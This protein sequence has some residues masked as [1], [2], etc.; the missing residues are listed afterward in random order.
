MEGS[1][2]SER[3]TVARNHNDRD[4]VRDGVGVDGQ[5]EHQSIRGETSGCKQV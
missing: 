3:V 5:R 2:P 1:S 4:P